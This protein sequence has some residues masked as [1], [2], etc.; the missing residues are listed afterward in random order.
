MER[1]RATRG[2]LRT[3]KHSI[4]ARAGITLLELTIVIAVLSVAVGM[5][6]STLVSLSRQRDVARE[7]AEVS[8]AVQN[9]LETIRGRP[10][11]LVA[12]LYDSDPSND[13]DGPGTAPGNRFAIEGFSPLGGAAD[14]LVGTILIPER[15]LDDGSWQVREDLELP[16]LGLPRDLDGDSIVDGLDHRADLV[17]LPLQVRVDWQGRHGVRSYSITTMLAQVRR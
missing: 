6:A 3:T 14:G 1:A 8:A 9:V 2:M 16:E 17:R 5:H 12:S 13:P 15:R 4:R 10:F 7:S 11:E